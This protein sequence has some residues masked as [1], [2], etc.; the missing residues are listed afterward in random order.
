MEEKNQISE[1]VSKFMENVKSVVNVDSVIGTPFEAGKGIYLIPITKVS[2][3]FVAGGGE[4]GCEKKLLK[5]RNSLPL[6]GG[7]SGGVTV[8]PIGFIEIKEKSCKL[9]RIDEK[10]V[11]QNILDKI[12]SILEGVSSIINKGDKSEK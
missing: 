11:Y 5:K 2:V 6:A 7:G 1:L 12:P 9:I 8:S 4:Y 3:G 10:S